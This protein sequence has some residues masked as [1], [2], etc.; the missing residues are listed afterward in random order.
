MSPFGIDRG[1]ML[2]RLEKA[3]QRAERS[4]SLP[5]LR[6]ALK[7]AEAS[8][9]GGTEDIERARRKL[10]DMEQDRGVSADLKVIISNANVR[11]KLASADELEYYRDSLVQALQRAREMGQVTSRIALTAKTQLQRL[12]VR[13]AV[14]RALEHGSIDELAAAIQRADML[15]VPMPEEKRRLVAWKQVQAQISQASLSGHV[16]QLQAAVQLA[17]ELGYR[18]VDLNRLK[19]AS[20]FRVGQRIWVGGK[21]GHAATVR[22]LGD[23]DFG[24][25][26]W[27]GVEFD[28]QIGRHDGSVDGERFFTCRDGYGKFVRPQVI[29]LLPGLDDDEEEEEHDQNHEPPMASKCYETRLSQDSAVIR[30]DLARGIV[31]SEHRKRFAAKGSPLH[32]RAD[33][34]HSRELEAAHDLRSIR[35][36]SRL[37]SGGKQPGECTPWAQACLKSAGQY[38]DQPTEPLLDTVKWQE[39]KIGNKKEASV[40]QPSH[41]ERKEPLPRKPRSQTESWGAK[42]G[43]VNSKDDLEST[44]EMFKRDADYYTGSSKEASKGKPNRS[45]RPGAPNPSTTAASLADEYSSDGSTSTSG[46]GARSKPGQSPGDPPSS[47]QTYRSGGAAWRSRGG[48]PRDR[49]RDRDAEADSNNNTT[50]EGGKGSGGRGKRPGVGPA[51]RGRDDQGGPSQDSDRTAPT[52]GG[53]EKKP[54]GTQRGGWR[55]YAYDD[56]DDD[57][58]DGQSQRGRR[59]KDRKEGKSASRSDYGDDYDDEDDDFIDREDSPEHPEGRRANSREG[60]GSTGG[61]GGGGESP[62]S[63]GDGLSGPA[64]SWRHRMAGTF[65]TEDSLQKELELTAFMQSRGRTTGDIC[66][67]RIG[68]R[69]GPEMSPPSYL[70][71]DVDLKNA[72]SATMAMQTSRVLEMCSRPLHQDESPL[73]LSVKILPSHLV[74]AGADTGQPRVRSLSPG[75]RLHPMITTAHE[76]ASPIRRLDARDAACSRLQIEGGVSV[77]HRDILPSATV[78]AP[79]P[80]PPAVHHKEIMSSTDLLLAQSRPP[81]EVRHPLIL[82]SRELSSSRPHSPE[83]VQ[84]PLIQPS[85]ELSPQHRRHESSSPRVEH[86]LIQ[87]SS[88]VDRPGSPPTQVEHPLI[89]PSSV[90]SPRLE[91]D[92]QAV[93]HPLIH[94]ASD[95]MR[96]P[97]PGPDKFDTDDDLFRAFA[98]TSALADAPSP[99]SGGDGL[100]GGG[101]VSPIASQLLSDFPSRAPSQGPSQTHSPRLPAVSPTPSQTFSPQLSSTQHQ[102]QPFQGGSGG[103][104]GLGLNL[105]GLGGP[106]SAPEA[107]AAEAS[108]GAFRPL[109]PGLEAGEP[110]GWASGGGLGGGL[111]GV[112]SGPVPVGTMGTTASSDFRSAPLAATSDRTLDANRRESAASGTSWGSGFTQQTPPEA[113]VAEARRAGWGEAH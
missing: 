42:L 54:K 109:S 14:L 53:Y 83:Q 18:S 25:G 66:D 88:A 62:N 97:K 58:Y 104:L 102:H 34:P 65:L 110:V 99:R 45:N 15:A 59:G 82:S 69:P 40:M 27:V 106:S 43:G 101:A 98:A 79:P 32:D 61:G 90:L 12:T 33:S 30:A 84:H 20:T 80:P 17:E 24:P 9:L 5:H 41:P 77:H 49:D 38:P 112:S 85:S 47:N 89:Q 111:G 64:F 16:G 78:L 21:G 60:G 100:G 50:R 55:S 10:Y 56:E 46:R 7:E 19:A 91:G 22:Y 107:Y 8:G 94:R 26:Q 44:Q 39:A 93:K 81:P 37:G 86:E 68:L 67:S 31:P 113:T 3:V 52:F 103:G 63:G 1:M 48:P 105:A 87:P 23:T 108:S 70:S 29:R 73:S 13:I 4:K 57:D 35:R 6:H 51:R 28:E 71:S 75:G 2:R 96:L 72:F 74:E 76:L 11:F 95:V 92:G 36:N